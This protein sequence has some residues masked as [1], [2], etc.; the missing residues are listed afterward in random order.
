MTTE[1][2][3]E[4]IR[5]AEERLLEILRSSD[6]P[7]GPLELRKRL[8]AELGSEGIDEQIASIAVWGVLERQGLWFHRP[9]QEALQTP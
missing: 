5:F 8:L 3:N 7:T 6:A 2:E 1:Q 9:K 4:L